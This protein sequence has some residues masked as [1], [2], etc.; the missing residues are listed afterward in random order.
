MGVGVGEEGADGQ[1]DLGDGEGGAPVV[2][3][4]IEADGARAVDVA[5]VDA[6]AEDHLGGLEGVFIRSYERS[7]E[8]DL[9][10]IGQGTRSCN[11][12]WYHH[13]HHSS[14]AYLC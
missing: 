12:H 5:V 14:S 9:S 11:R 4:D 1:E 6:R 3:E 10:P 7:L 13:P 2:L 8:W